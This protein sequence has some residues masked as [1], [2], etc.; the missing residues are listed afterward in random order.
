MYLLQWVQ[1]PAL[2]AVGYL[3]LS[4]WRSLRDA[5]PGRA[6][7][8]RLAVLISPRILCGVTAYLALGLFHGTFTAAKTMMV[9]LP[10][11]AW[12]WALADI[13]AALH[14]GD[15]WRLIPLMRPLTRA[16]QWIY[17]P[18]WLLTL[19]GV[20]FYV[21]VFAPDDLRRQYFKTFLFCWIVLGNLVA[22]AFLSG[23]PV[24]YEALTGS[25]RFAPL[26]DYLGFSQ[27]LPWSSVDVSNRLWLVHLAGDSAL[28][29]G[30]S[31]F[32]S[33]HL[34]MATLWLVTLR[35]LWPLLH[36]PMVGLVVAIG[37]GSVHLGWHY[38]IDG[39]FSIAVTLTAW[40][41][42]GARVRWQR[43]ARWLPISRKSL[44]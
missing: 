31:A 30:I 11:L 13:D 19:T 5:E 1:V 16:L 28:G 37:I 32:P 27:G 25:G 22:L 20:S 39:Y 14:G 4:G 15:A 33:L 17:Y 26:T 41:S 40:W 23:G 9:D 18:A 29:S 36:W 24:Y 6:F 2:C 10:P 21:S 35:R 43:P 8:D 42:F 3:I 44:S 12:D 34:A 38:A 7:S